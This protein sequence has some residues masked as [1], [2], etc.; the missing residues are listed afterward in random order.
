MQSVTI[1]VKQEVFGFVKGLGFLSVS[2]YVNKLLD[3][4]MTVAKKEEDEL[5][6]LHTLLDEGDVSGYVDV[7]ENFFKN[8]KTR[9]AAIRGKYSY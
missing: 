8:M 5:E 3:H 7:D 6:S 1:D 4:Q 2:D 9:F